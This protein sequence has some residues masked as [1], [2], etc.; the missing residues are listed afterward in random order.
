LIWI[1]LPS[2]V[3]EAK[4][5]HIRLSNP[6]IQQGVVEVAG[7]LDFLAACGFEV[8]AACDSS[9]TGG[10][11]DEG[12]AV[13]LD[14]SQL[15]LVHAGLQELQRVLAAVTAAAPLQ[16]QQQQ[17]QQ[18]S[19]Q[20]QQ[21]QQQRTPCQSAAAA[22]S[23]TSSPQ[24]V[25][26]GGSPTVT[27]DTQV[28]LPAAPDTN[29]P[30][31]F[32]ERTPADV[33]AEYAAMV[34]RRAAGEVVASKAWKDAQLGKGIAGKHQLKESSVRV[35]FPEVRGLL[36]AVGV[37]IAL[38]CLAHTRLPL[39]LLENCWGLQ[40]L[41]LSGAAEGLC[42]VQAAAFAADLLV[43]RCLCRQKSSCTRLCT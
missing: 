6:R 23:S 33:K 24:P 30:D 15:S 1:C 31:W 7:G 36:G 10:D 17:Q 9:H 40:V 32:F 19:K 38:L 39:A 28:L 11:A 27:R 37:G 5:R 2:L 22:A 20:Q 29:V 16:Q 13:F 43:C 14:D 41:C 21:Q 34:R 35:R 26:A 4:F 25:P 18:Q 8:H 42:L 12:F 3:Q